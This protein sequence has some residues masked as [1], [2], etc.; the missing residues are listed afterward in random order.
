MKELIKELKLSAKHAT[1][2]PWHIGHINEDTDAA[3]IVGSNGE[4]V[5]EN[6]EPRNQW[7]MC[8]ATPENIL[9]LIERLEFLEGLKP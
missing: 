9:K 3:D 2:G 8:R 6:V 1:P 7:F 5:A 4:I